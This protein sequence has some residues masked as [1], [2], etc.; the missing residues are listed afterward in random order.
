MTG[1]AI[2]V[3]TAQ[4]GGTFQ[5]TAEFGVGDQYFAALNRADALQADID[6]EA[7]PARAYVLGPDGVPIYAGGAPNWRRAQAA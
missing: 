1:F 2:R 4:R 7:F 3:V 5:T 6:A